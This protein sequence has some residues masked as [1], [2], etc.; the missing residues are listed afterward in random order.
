MEFYE[1]QVE[2]TLRLLLIAATKFSYF[3]VS[4]KIAKFSMRNHYFL[5]K[6][7]RGLQS[8]KLVSSKRDYVLNRKIL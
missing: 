4:I 5:N 7:Q 1:E 2:P 3:S 6:K 8:P